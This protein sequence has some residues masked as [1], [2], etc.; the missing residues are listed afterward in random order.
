MSIQT[1]SAATKSEVN[2]ST[3]DGY[4]FAQRLQTGEEEKQLDDPPIECSPLTVMPDLQLPLEGPRTPYA[5]VQAFQNC[6]WGHRQFKK[7]RRRLNPSKLYPLVLKHCASFSTFPA[8][9]PPATAERKGMWPITAKEAQAI[10]ELIP[11]DTGRL[12]TMLLSGNK[13]GYLEQRIK[14][15]ESRISFMEKEH[16]EAA[17]EAPPQGYGFP[18]RYFEWK[19]KHRWQ[20]KLKSQQQ[21]IDNLQEQL[22]GL[23]AQLAGL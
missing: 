6:L 10:A 12:Y 7:S 17:S 8:D 19:A 4:H 5:W 20:V 3:L 13:R 22:A 16:K 14:Q 21:Y 1:M 23:K 15:T 2:L 11:G 18:P 9:E